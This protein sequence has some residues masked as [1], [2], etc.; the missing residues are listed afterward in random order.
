MLAFHI[1]YTLFA[2]SVLTPMSGWLMAGLLGLTGR[3]M[4]GNEDLLA[5]IPFWGQTLIFVINRDY[6]G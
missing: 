4:V 5:F 6:H 2:V 1:Y 3:S